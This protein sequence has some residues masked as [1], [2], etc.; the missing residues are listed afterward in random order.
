MNSKMLNYTFCKFMSIIYM[1]KILSKSINAKIS[2]R[3]RKM[4]IYK[5]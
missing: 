2:D 4:K 3:H 5:F 1:L